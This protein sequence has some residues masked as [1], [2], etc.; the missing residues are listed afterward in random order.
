MALQDYS[1]SFS[2]NA[3]SDIEMQNEDVVAP[4]TRSYLYQKFKFVFHYILFVV[5]TVICLV[6]EGKTE[7]EKIACLSYLTSML[8]EKVKMYRK[9]FILEIRRFV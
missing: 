3:L 7:R 8:P 1:I 9:R 5:C 4:Q 6:Y 2:M